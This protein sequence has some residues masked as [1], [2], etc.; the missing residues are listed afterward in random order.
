MKKS[1]VKIRIGI[2]LDNT[3]ISYDKAFQ[4][5]AITSGLVD[6]NCKLNK[7]AIRDLIR[8][9]PDGEFDWQKLQGYVY[10][11]GIVDA[12]LFPGVYRFLWR[13]KER[14]IDVEIVSHKT[15]FGHF[16]SNKISL[17][18]SATNFLISHGLLDNKNPL[19]KK[20][21]YKKSKKEKIDYIKQNNYEYFIDDLEEII[22]S[23]ELEGKK[24][25]LFSRETLPVNNTNNFIAQSWEEISYKILG[26]WSLDE[27][28]NMANLIVNNN[29]VDSIEKLKGH[30]NSA[31][32]KLYLSDTNQAALKI[33]PE[34]SYHDRLGTEF[35]STKIF[36][37]LDIKNVQRP[38]SFDNSL[39]I[40]SYEWI[41]GERVIRY[42]RKELK[43]AL[44]FLSVLHK[45]SKA[46]Q[47]E[48]FSLAS[49]ACL[50]GSEIENQIKRR[51]LQFDELS[52][53]YSELGR[54][55]K[56]DFKP[57]FKKIS[58]WSKASW[59]INSSYIEPITKNELILSPSDF[60]F[61][62]SLCSKNENLIFHDFEYFGW[63]DPVKL[64][65]DFSHNAAMNLTEE[66]EQLWF[67]EAS[68][69]YGKHLLGR[70][71]ASWP[72]YGLN[73]CLIILNE[74]KDEVWSRRCSSDD[75]KSNLRDEFLETQL[76]KS[77]IKL[78]FLAKNYKSKFF[79]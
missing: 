63:D 55:L 31:I 16:D 57:L 28:N 1:D 65:S 40:A 59:P 73:W 43:S 42:G 64:L 50:S 5:A 11:E 78:N 35:K 27:V 7:K 4:L 66:V 77:K 34:I 76:T 33:Y 9:K 25:I 14:K 12:V 56:D 8:K 26:N 54:F 22:F 72:M 60:G 69:I 39:G 68:D 61:H 51:L 45:N 3:I 67:S 29:M 47:F 49:D 71:T 13:C 79:W 37:E 70:L 36:K 75:S 19:I 21:T 10:G 20:V 74:F 44:S 48:S 18:D 38:I 17:R 52:I 2:D 41:E 6:E 32:Y 23:E 46:E 58:S 30:G 62:N 15:K 24:G 53:K